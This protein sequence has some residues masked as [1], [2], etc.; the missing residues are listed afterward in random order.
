MERKIHGR[1]VSEAQIDE[2]V[3]E[4]EAGYDVE[5]LKSR[6]GRPVRGAEASQVIP[7]RLTVEELDAVMARAEREHLNRS[8]AIRAA[9]AVW[10]NVA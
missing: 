9:L 5:E 4:A 3:V 2:W 7:V 8:E 6:R 1:E 10:A